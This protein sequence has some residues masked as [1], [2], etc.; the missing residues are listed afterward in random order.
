MM[1]LRSTR[2]T[3]LAVH[4]PLLSPICM[5]FLPWNVHPPCGFETYPRTQLWNFNHPLNSADA[6][7]INF[8]V[9]GRACVEKTYI[10]P[11]QAIWF[12]LFWSL[13]AQWWSLQSTR[14]KRHP[15]RSYEVVWMEASIPVKVLLRMFFWFRL[16]Y[17]S[18]NVRT[19]M[20]GVDG[21]TGTPSQVTVT[22]HLSILLG[23]HLLCLAPSQSTQRGVRV[24]CS[25]Q[26]HNVSYWTSVGCHSKTLT[27]QRLH[28][29]SLPR[30]SD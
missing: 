6:C 24:G 9:M 11:N 18:N 3:C 2:L 1:P 14:T 8:L 20:L 22:P 4:M 13:H 27:S 23:R 12:R 10:Y 5:S 26:G 15:K 19:S 17:T 29:G 16:C 7:D 30:Q 28:T 21:R 25:L